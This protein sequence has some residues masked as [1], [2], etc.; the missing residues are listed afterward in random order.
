MTDATPGEILAIQPNA[1]YR[2]RLEKG[3]EVTC[4]VDPLVRMGVTRL[5]VRDRVA[6]TRSKIDSSRG[7]IVKRLG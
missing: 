6:V 1:L 7:R 5:S 4:H 2:V 3:G